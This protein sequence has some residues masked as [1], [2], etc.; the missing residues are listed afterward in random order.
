M[1]NDPPPPPAVCTF[2]EVTDEEST[3]NVSKASEYFDKNKVTKVPLIA[4]ESDIYKVENQAWVC[5]SIIKPDE[6]G[7]L[8]YRKKTYN[9]YLIKFRGCFATKEQAVKHI[10]KIMKVDKHFDVHLIPT[11]QWASMEDTEIEDREYLNEVVSDIMKGYFKKE[12][13]KIVRMRDRIGDTE[14]SERSDESSAFFEKCAIQ[15]NEPR[16][17]KH[18]QLHFSSLDEL[19]TKYEIKAAGGWCDHGEVINNDVVNSVV[20][21]ILLD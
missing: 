18:Q 1:Q 17:N 21:E 20:S 15:E 7:E 12:N 6:Y 19:S 8:S 3:E 4:L 13:E 10:E 16:V 14:T 2:T 11:F 9:G 5:F